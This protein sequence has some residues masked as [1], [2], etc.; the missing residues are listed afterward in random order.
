MKQCDLCDNPY[1]YMCAECNADV[2]EMDCKTAA[3][4][5][6]TYIGCGEDIPAEVFAYEQQCGDCACC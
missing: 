3:V 1:P 2:T 5:D 4:A 6:K